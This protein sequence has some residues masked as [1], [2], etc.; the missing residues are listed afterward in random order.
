MPE[1]RPDLPPGW[2]PNPTSWRFWEW[3]W[4]ICGV[5][6]ALLLFALAGAVAWWAAVLLFVAVVILL[7]FPRPEAGTGRGA[8]AATAGQDLG[9]AVIAFA[10]ALP[11]PCFLVDAVG[12]VRFANERS[13][14]AFPLKPG[15]LLTTR[16]RAP[17]FVSALQRVAAGGGAARVEFFERVPTERWFVAWFAPLGGPAGQRPET[18]VLIIDDLTEQ[19]RAER[20]RADFVA[21]ASHELR[22]PLASLTGFIETLQG[23][24]KDDPAARE[25]FLAIMHGQSQRMSR[26]IDDLLSLNRIEMKAHMRPSDEVDLVSVLQHVLDAFEPLARELDVALEVELPEGSVSVPGDRDELVQ[27]FSNLVENALKYGREGKR[28]VVSLIRP[29][30]ARSPCLVSVRDFGPGIAAEHLPRLTERFYRVDDDR[31]NRGTGLGLA[32][33]KHILNRHRARLTI[34]SEPGQGA[35]FSVRFDVSTFAASAPLDQ[36]KVV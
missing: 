34:E 27:V 7:G 24:A 30:G 21:N 9:A 22:T 12:M 6:I 5:G 16:L 13:R 10:D 19:R 31:Q 17:D 33:V 18:I 36:R 15:D 14:A 11:D 1:S 32:I 8:A 20:A 23:P 26:L 35:L 3:R 2:Q 4:A 28:V 29:S 25:R